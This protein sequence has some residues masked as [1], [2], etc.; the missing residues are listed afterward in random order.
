MATHWMSRQPAR[1]RRRSG[2]SDMLRS[3]RRQGGRRPTAPSPRVGSVPF[4][5]RNPSDDRPQQRGSDVAPP[6]SRLR[7]WAGATSWS[8]CAACRHEM[9]GSGEAHRCRPR[10]RARRVAPFAGSECSAERASR[11]LQ[12]RRANALRLLARVDPS[13]HPR[14]QSGC[15]RRPTRTASASCSTRRP[16]RPPIGRRRGRPSGARLRPSPAAMKSRAADC[17][18]RRELNVPIWRGLRRPVSVSIPSTRTTHFS[19]CFWTVG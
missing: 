11:R 5:A 1:S 7:P 19:R 16:C 2:A 9:P 18:A 10:R 8:R 3:G 6:P 13:E 4:R 15:D 17:A 14:C 12:G